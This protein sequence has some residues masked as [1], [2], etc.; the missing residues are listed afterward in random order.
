M[1]NPSPLNINALKREAFILRASLAERG[2][3]IS[4]SQALERIAVR[5][6]YRDWNTLSAVARGQPKPLMLKIDQAVEGRYLG[7]AFKGK[8]VGAHIFGDNHTRVSIHLDEAIDVVRFSS[9]SSW[10]KRITGTLDRNG[11][12]VEKCSENIPHLVVHNA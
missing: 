3:R 11:V 12:S 10:R 6:G 9:F 5:E 2:E 4:H 7:H 1:E 8:I